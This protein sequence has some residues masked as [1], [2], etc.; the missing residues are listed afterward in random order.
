MRKTSVSKPTAVGNAKVETNSI[1]IWEKG[2]NDGHYE[3]PYWN[4]A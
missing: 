4:T 2:K 1:E 3:Q